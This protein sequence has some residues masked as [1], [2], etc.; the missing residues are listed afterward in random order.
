MPPAKKPR[1]EK[2]VI[3]LVERV[4]VSGTRG[5]KVVLAKVDTGAS[6]TVADTRLAAEVGLGPITDTVTIRGSTGIVKETRALV[7]ARIKL[8]QRTHDLSVAISDRGDMKYPI[9]VG[10]DILG[11]GNYLIDVKKRARLKA[12]KKRGA[13][14]PAVKV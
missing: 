5:S 13:R 6:R 10:M 8:R 14:K 3:G 9:L 11:K 1:K 7:G 4:T 2:Q 12:K